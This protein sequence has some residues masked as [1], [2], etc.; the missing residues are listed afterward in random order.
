MAATE[1]KQQLNRERQRRFQARRASQTEAL[2]RELDALRR[3]VDDLSVVNAA[4]EREIATLRS[5]KTA[6]SEALRA[7]RQAARRPVK[8]VEK[9]Q[10]SRN[11]RSAI[12]E[13]AKA[14]RR[15]KDLAKYLWPPTRK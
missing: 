12:S 4:L 14:P 3:Q 5:D 10:A 8:M 7:A 6:L 9:S 2:H 11:R 1:R 15:D 13:P